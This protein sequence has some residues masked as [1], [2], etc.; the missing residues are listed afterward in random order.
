MAAWAVQRDGGNP[1]LSN[2][3][4]SPPAMRLITSYMRQTA[5]PERASATTYSIGSGA[6]K[7]PPAAA[8]CLTGPGGHDPTDADNMP[9]GSSIRCGLRVQIGR[10]GDAKGMPRGCQGD[11]KGLNDENF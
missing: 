2:H 10:D 3:N 7:L 8:R 9:L 5:Y 4:S 11:G 6:M 1:G